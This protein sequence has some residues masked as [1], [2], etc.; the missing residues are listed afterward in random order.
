[1][2]DN[3]IQEQVN[4]RL[5][6]TDYKDTSVDDIAKNIHVDRNKDVIIEYMSGDTEK[7]CHIS[8]LDDVTEYPDTI[9]DQVTKLK[10]SLIYAKTK[11]G[12]GYWRLERKDDEFII[13]LDTE[14]TDSITVTT[15]D[16]LKDNIDDLKLDLIDLRMIDLYTDDQG[17][18]YTR[19][20]QETTMDYSPVFLGIVAVILYVLTSLS[21]LTNPNNLQGMESVI[22]INTI[23][24]ILLTLFTIKPEILHIIRRKIL[25]KPSYEYEYE[26]IIDEPDDNE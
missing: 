26:S 24:F 14:F 7:L 12:N 18:L 4:K 3:L 25:D 21:I 13:P 22:H 6:D 10:S 8:E 17:N 19:E 15:I 2:G 23:I 20:L 11:D 9:D 16:D 1:M 5:Q